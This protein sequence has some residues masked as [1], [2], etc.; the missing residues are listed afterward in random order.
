MADDGTIGALEL[1]K[2]GGHI[3]CESEETAVV[4][5]M[6]RAAIEAGAAHQSLP[7]PRIAEALLALEAKERSTLPPPL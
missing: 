4:Y 3:I 7:L 2:A 1:K 5:G 6:P